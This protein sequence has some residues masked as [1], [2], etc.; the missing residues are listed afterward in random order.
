MPGPGVYKNVQKSAGDLIKKGFVSDNTKISCSSTSS[1]GVKFTSES[2]VSGDTSKMKFGLS[3]KPVKD[4]EV[5][6]LEVTQAG[7]FSGELKYSGIDSTL[8]TL[9]AS[10][11]SKDS[12]SLDVEYGHEKFTFNSSVDLLNFKSSYGLLVGHKGLLVG[13]SVDLGEKLDFTKPKYACAL[14]YNGGDYHAAVSTSTF[15]SYKGTYSHKVNTDLSLGAVVDYKL[16]AKVPT[17][18]AGLKY[19]IDADSTLNAKIG[20]TG[21]VTLGF[22]QKLKSNVEFNAGTTISAK[23]MQMSNGGFGLNFSF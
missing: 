10:T 22:T 12:A 11:G 4:L 1:N 5:S 20:C 18:A 2:T 16:S 15:S 8:F 13:G 9:A 7:A 23:D 3:F 19:K 17:V 14:G 6:K 21:D